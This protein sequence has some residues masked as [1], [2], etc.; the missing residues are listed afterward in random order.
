MILGLFFISLGGLLLHLRIHPPFENGRFNGVHSIASGI[1]I[2]SVCVI[3]LLFFFRK[4]TQLAYL[5]NGLTVIFGT[6]FMAHFSIA[7]MKLP[8]NMTDIFLRTTLAD[9]VI[10]FSKFF[11]GKALYD[12]YLEGI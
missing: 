7:N 8:V 2:F 1:G 10:L 9:I 6:I 5:L 4:T 11:I 12:L 3:N